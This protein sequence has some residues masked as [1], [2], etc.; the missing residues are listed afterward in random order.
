[1]PKAEF[2]NTNDGNTSRRFFSNPEVV[3][4]ITG[5]DFNLINRLKVILEVLT[6]GYKVDLKKLRIM[7]TRLPNCMYDCTLG[8]Q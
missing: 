5:V 7:H 4:E 6:S 1:M 2:G 3:A 8:I